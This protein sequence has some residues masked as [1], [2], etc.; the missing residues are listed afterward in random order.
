MLCT[1]VWSGE[2][3]KSGFTL[4]SENYLFQGR[5]AVPSTPVKSVNFASAVEMDK[6]NS[7]DEEE[8]SVLPLR[9]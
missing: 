9:W 2:K 6:S 3:I 5:D 7:S 4:K 8:F 1:A